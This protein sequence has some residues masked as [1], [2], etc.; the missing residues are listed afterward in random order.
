M[1]NTLSMNDKPSNIFNFAAK[2]AGYPTEFVIGT[3]T[4][5]N[6][7]IAT[8]F[9][10]ISSLYS[11]SVDQTENGISTTEPVYSV[12]PLFGAENIQAEAA[13]RYIT[14]Q[15]GIR[16]PVLLFLSLKSYK[17]DIVVGVVE[18][19]KNVSS[20]KGESS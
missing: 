9:G 15:L 4:N 14:E 18:A 11:V 2:I 10:K 5:Q 20:Q 8:Q 6:L 3:F 12:N 17:R 16:K 13:A 1:I 7:I 19:I